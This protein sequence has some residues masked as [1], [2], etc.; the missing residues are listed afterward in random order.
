MLL[1]TPK[2]FEIQRAFLIF[3]IQRTDSNGGSITSHWKTK[4][5]AMGIHEPMGAP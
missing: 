4:K 2:I 1:S 3:L 5:E